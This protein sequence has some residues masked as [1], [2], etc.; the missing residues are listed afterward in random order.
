MDYLFFK[1]G[2]NAILKITIY[3]SQG[4]LILSKNMSEEEEISVGHLKTG[5]YFYIIQ[6]DDK[7]FSGKFL[8]G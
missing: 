4:I 7:L 2:S 3:D 1:N 6:E 5:L 8:K